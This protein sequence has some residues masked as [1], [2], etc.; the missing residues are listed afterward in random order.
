MSFTS[1]GYL[2]LPAKRDAG[3]FALD[4]AIVCAIITPMMVRWC[5]CAFAFLVA[6]SSEAANLEDLYYAGEARLS[7]EGGQP[8]GSQVILLH[9]TSDPQKSLI[10]E[11]ALVV[12]PDR[13]VDDY[14][15]NLQVKGDAFTVSDA[16]NTIEGGG[17]LFGPA[18][19]WSY[20]RGTY[21]STTGAQIEDENYLSDPAVLVA[22]KKITQPG[23]GVVYMDIVLHAI[24]APTFEVFEK[25]LLKK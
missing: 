4:S 8:Y 19:H 13:S 21:K 25:A 5:V 18:W 7:G 3:L 22:R 1:L 11:R 6:A 10:I 12:K 15:M 23:K 2:A 14:T 17:Q 20:F 24:T 9:K 16:K